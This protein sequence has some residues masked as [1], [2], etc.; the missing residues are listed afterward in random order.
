[1][2]T[3]RQSH[4]AD[5]L[6]ERRAGALLAIARA[7][8]ASRLG[9]AAVPP[10]APAAGADRDWLAAPGASFVTLMLGGALRGCIG[11][12]QA[13]RPLAEDVAANARAAAFADPRFPPLTA[14]ELGPTRFEVSVLTPPVRL[15]AAGEAEALAAVVPGRDGLMLIW[16]DSRG[17]FLPQLWEHFPDPAELLRQLKRKAGLA[18]DFWAPDAEL[19]TFSVDKA[20]EPG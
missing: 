12:I 19:W 11:S 2:T 14:G 10:P 6:D 8:V 15:T 1:M 20:V 3:T 7:A 17:V 16:G 13:R 5:E 18:A 4:G 9:V